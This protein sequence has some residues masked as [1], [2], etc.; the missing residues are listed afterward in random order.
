[1]GASSGIG[2]E[3]A[4]RFAAAGAQVV[5]SARTAT[6]LG[7]LADEVTA[8]GGQVVTVPALGLRP[9]LRPQA[10]TVV[11]DLYLMLSL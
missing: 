1:M 6:A 8:A 10:P 7:S 4:R 3:A 5:A 2:R 11:N 9:D